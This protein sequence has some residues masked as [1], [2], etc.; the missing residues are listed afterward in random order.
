MQK[1]Q[2]AGAFVSTNS[3]VQGEQVPILWKELLKL[4]VIINFA[5]QPFKWESEIKNKAAVHCVI[6]GFS[7]INKKEKFLFANDSQVKKVENINPYLLDAEIVII[8]NRNYHIQNKP[9]MIYGNMP[10]DDGNLI[11]SKEE[12]EE[13]LKENPKNEIFIKKYMG[14]N[15]LI[16]NKKRWCLWLKDANPKLLRESKLISERIMK[17]KIFRD[18][19]NRP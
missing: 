12:V 2:I 6:I 11:L 16:N 15:E 13:L 14:G 17:T 18:N 7:C 10:I 3:I 5:Y 9:S 1:T 4:G 19:S 8:E